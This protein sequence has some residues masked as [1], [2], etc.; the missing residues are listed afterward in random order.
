MKR[1]RTTP[2]NIIPMIK[3]R[4]SLSFG[5]LLAASVHF[6]AGMEAK[7]KDCALTDD[8]CHLASSVPN[9]GDV[10]IRTLDANSVRGRQ[11]L[12]MAEHFGANRLEWIYNVDQDYVDSATSLGLK[13][14]TTMNLNAWPYVQAVPGYLDK[15][16]SRDLS[17]EPVTRYNFRK[18]DDWET[19]FFSPDT[20]I[21]AWRDFYVEYLKNHY[22][23]DVSTI[24]RDDQVATAG[25]IND[26]GSFTDASIE[27]FQR[28]LSSR[29]S[30]EELERLDIDDPEN[31]DIRPHLIERGAPPPGRD[32]LRWDGGPLLR[33]YTRA[34][35]EAVADFYRDVRERIESETGKKIP[36]A[37]NHT[38]QWGPIEQEFDYSLGEF[39]IHQLQIETM[40][41]IGRRAEQ[42]GRLQ[43]LQGVLDGGWK[44]RPAEELVAMNRQF[45]ATAYAL[46]MIAMVPW[47]MYM[48][49]VAPRYYGNVAD[50]ADLFKFISANRHLFN[51]YHTALLTG[52]DPNGSRHEWRANQ[53][54]KLRSK[55]ETAVFRIN[56][57]G[58]L[59][60]IR[61]N[62]THTPKYVIHLVD[63]NNHAEAFEISIDPH[64]LTGSS[65]ARV[66]LHT[67]GSDPVLVSEGSESTLSIPPLKP[68]GLLV[69]EP[70][71]EDAARPAP[72]TLKEPVNPVVPK[73]AKYVL[74]SDDRIEIRT[75]NDP[76]AEWRPY[77]ANNA[78]VP[79][80]VL[81]ARSVRS[82]SDG[83]LT[84]SPTAKWRFWT[85]AN[86]VAD[87][88]A[89][90]RSPLLHAEM[91]MSSKD[92]EGTAS[93]DRFPDGAPLFRNGI[94]I[95]KA[96][97]SSGDV[98]FRIPV[99]EKAAIFQITAALADDTET[100][101]PSFR[102]QV[103]ADG[104]PFYESPI[105]NTVKG[106]IYEQ[107]ETKRDLSLLLPHDTREIEVSLITTG[108]FPHH[109]RVIWHHAGFQSDNQ[110]LW[111]ERRQ[112]LNFES[113][114]VRARGNGGDDDTEFQWIGD[115]Q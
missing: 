33:L 26:G 44:E 46:G 36:W 113:D 62:Q 99:P 81:E 111:D 22:A 100:L 109:N 56:R 55:F 95:Q 69:F 14:G 74:K 50:Y 67:P 23:V 86:P 6:L 82:T 110:G 72:P 76:N 66:M 108:W 24:M 107:E 5:L 106:V 93:K 4:H 61:Q 10:I 30:P 37:C 96:I 7:A 104:R 103:S 80:G 90:E 68:W 98:S 51:D 88:D 73:E 29:V 59:G 70:L 45:I 75:S 77:A 35:R 28:F 19:K 43:G 54:L 12:K 40:A 16:T 83:A 20:N 42:I 78:T 94:E 79:D 27:M 2:L 49:G 32:W 53:Q 114:G 52:F 101:R 13:V 1:L 11:A 65:A 91:I 105:I 3:I 58:I 87:V 8:S 18:F 92:S 57:E 84:Y 38:G 64:A 9:F 17:G 31:F 34:Q 102:I 21:Q 112:L 97:G 25:L 15:F 71:Q 60:T 47:D 63:W 39:Y 41:E 89:N 115:E 85:F 48:P